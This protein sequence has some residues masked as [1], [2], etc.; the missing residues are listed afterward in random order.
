[1]WL[2]HFF[3]NISVSVD[4]NARLSLYF[5]K[6][7]ISGKMTAEVVDYLPVLS[8]VFHRDACEGLEHRD[9]GGGDGTNLTSGRD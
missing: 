9:N 4:L 2:S 3:M 6:R 8:I 5:T 1:M 7:W